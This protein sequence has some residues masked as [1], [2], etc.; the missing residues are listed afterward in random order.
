M[1]NNNLLVTLTFPFFVFLFF[2]V[3]SDDIAIVI[4]VIDINSALA[5]GRPENRGK[6]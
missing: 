4:N 6:P 1:L 5:E 2:F 3:N